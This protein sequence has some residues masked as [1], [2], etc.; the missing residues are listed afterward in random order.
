MIAL[1]QGLNGFIMPT[2]TVGALTGHAAHAGSASAV[3]G[4]L[5]F[6]IGSSSGFLLAWLTDGTPVPMLTDGTPVPMLTDGT[7]VPMAALMVAGACTMKLADLCRPRNFRVAAAH[8]S[9]R[10]VP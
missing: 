1:T 10:A 3:M 5:Q 9:G 7:P 4:T 2:G 8:P 6:L